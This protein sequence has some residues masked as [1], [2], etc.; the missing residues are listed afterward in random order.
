MKYSPRQ[1]WEAYAS[2]RLLP[3][4]ELEDIKMRPKRKPPVGVDV[5]DREAAE[6]TLRE[7]EAHTLEDWCDVK[8]ELL[9]APDRFVQGLLLGVVIAMVVFAFAM[10]YIG[11]KGIWG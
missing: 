6:E 1:V 8:G 2:Q 7:Y 5:L 3:H 9:T 4:K 11:A 10:F